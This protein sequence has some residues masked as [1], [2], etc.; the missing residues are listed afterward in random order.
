[1]TLKKDLIGKL[2]ITISDENS[3]DFNCNYLM[4]KFKKAIFGRVLVNF[5]STLFFKYLFS[6]DATHIQGGFETFTEFGL[7]Y[8]FVE[9]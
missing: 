6:K 8:S 4:Y 3:F 5:N 2:F 1:M 9:F 7:H